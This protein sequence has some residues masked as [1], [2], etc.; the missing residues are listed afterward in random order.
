MANGEI[1]HDDTMFFKTRLLQRHQKASACG[2]GLMFCQHWGESGACFTVCFSGQVV[3]G[4]L[5]HFQGF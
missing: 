1:A 5:V 2:K 4:I 3:Q